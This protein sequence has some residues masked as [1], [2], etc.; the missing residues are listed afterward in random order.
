MKIYFT[1]KKEALKIL[2]IVNI[3][4]TCF[5]YDYD[6]NLLQMESVRATEWYSCKICIFY[7]FSCLNNCLIYINP[8]KKSA[9]EF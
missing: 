3:R 2:N 7:Y 5:V 8:H 6:T 1:L 4:G 9:S